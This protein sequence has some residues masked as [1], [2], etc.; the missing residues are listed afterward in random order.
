MRNELFTITLLATIIILIT[1]L[2][3]KPDRTWEP[4]VKTKVVGQTVT[5]TEIKDGEPVLSVSEPKEIE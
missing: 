5:V 1:A 2:V 3:V 4:V